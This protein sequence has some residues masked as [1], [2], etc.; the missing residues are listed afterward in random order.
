MFASIAF[1]AIASRIDSGRDLSETDEVM[2]RG[3]WEAE[4][5]VSEETA[6]SLARA[7]NQHPALAKVVVRAR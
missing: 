7:V 5:A 2:A 3:N 1:G 4:T 6:R